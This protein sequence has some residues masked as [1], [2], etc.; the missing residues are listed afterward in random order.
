MPRINPPTTEELWTLCQSHPLKQVAVKF[1]LS[2]Q[3]IVARFRHEGLAGGTAKDP[4]P[5]EILEARNR[6]KESWDETTQRS[7]WVGNRGRQVR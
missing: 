3:D 2:V 1:G 6:I 4:S 7:R 5:D